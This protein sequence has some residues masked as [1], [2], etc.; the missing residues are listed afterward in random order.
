M[1]QGRKAGRANLSNKKKK[2]RN[3]A[4]DTVA[5]AAGNNNGIALANG[6]VRPRGPIVMGEWASR[7]GGSTSS[8]VANNPS[9]TLYAR[10]KKATVRFKE[11]V[12][13]M[14]PKSVYGGGSTE[15]LMDAAE[16]IVENDVVLDRTFMQDLKLTL[17]VRKRV[18]KSLDGGGD[19]GHAFFIQVLEY[20]WKSFLVKWKQQQ[21]ISDDPIP[22][23]EFDKTSDGKKFRNRFDALSI[24]DNLDMGEEDEND[25]YPDEDDD[26]DANATIARPKTENTHLQNLSFQEILYGDDRSAAIL[27]FADVNAIMGISIDHFAQLKQTM[28]ANAGGTKHPEHFLPKLLE[29]G[30]VSNFAIQQVSMLEHVLAAEFPHFNTIYRILG[31]VVCAGMIQVISE[32]VQEHSPVAALGDVRKETVEFVGDALECGFRDASDP[33]NKIKHLHKDFCFRWKIT[34][35]VLVKRLDNMFHSL[36]LYV[37]LEAPAE[38][39]KEIYEQWNFVKKKNDWLEKWKHLGGKRNILKTLRLVQ[40]YSNV[41]I[42]TGPSEF[43]TMGNGENAFGQPWHERNNPATKITDDLDHFLLIEMMPVLVAM[44]R[45][46]LISGPMPRDWDLYPGFCHITKWCADPHPPITLALAFTFHLI[47]T[48]IYEVQGDDDVATLQ[49]TSQVCWERYFH[50]LDWATE[51]IERSSVTLN[52]RSWYQYLDSMKSVNSLRWPR[53]GVSCA[54]Q[55]GERRLVNATFNPMLAGT[56]LLYLS[57]FNALENGS[58]MF[59]TFAQVR[60]V[61]HLY[62]ALLQ[63]KALQVGEVPFLDMLHKAFANSKAIWKSGTIPEQ[64]TTVK[65]FLVAVGYGVKHAQSKAEEIRACLLGERFAPY[66]GSLASFRK[67][68]R[69]GGNNYDR[70]EQLS[71][72]FKRVVLHDFRDDA[73]ILGEKQKQGEIHEYR[74]R[75]QQTIRSMRMD[76]DLLA[77]N[78]VSLGEYFNG[79]VYGVFEE[80]EWEDLVA[81][82]SL[83]MTKE[84]GWKEDDN[85]RRYSEMLVLARRILGVF[86]YK[87]NPLEEEEVKTVTAYFRD[88]FSNI[89]LDKVLWFTPPAPPE[90]S[91]EENTAGV[92]RATSAVVI[93]EDTKVAMA[94][95]GTPTTSSGSSSS[96]SRSTDDA[97]MVIGGE[98]KYKTNGGSVHDEEEDSKPI[99]VVTPNRND[100]E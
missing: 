26:T 84:L 27:F 69:N 40:I 37:R 51:E 35:P 38:E 29:T 34:S 17:R 50:Q 96:S 36:R 66:K 93:E 94:F 9:M 85:V 79:F 18:A 99:A 48:S 90:H 54:N 41:V 76:H 78:F 57:Y 71:S 83:E 72:S 92:A 98:D 97:D 3:K 6:N 14:V 55:I 81:E 32:F 2:G 67:R 5:A 56:F 19:E 77:I 63:S 65:H 4:N 39:E 74:E 100:T 49:K 22:S 53:I 82:V 30:V 13:S 42:N 44:C 24:E 23:S 7:E 59:D 58:R 21:N 91:G 87:E 80:L 89:P 52:R 25:Y 46:G 61:L 86:D 45:R 1:A 47:L 12:E 70:A 68:N 88:Y 15:E 75:L 16:Y 62:N 95:P 31:V 11:A 60:F 73:A 28:R 8:S 33:N 43:A 64:G 20:C 10:Y